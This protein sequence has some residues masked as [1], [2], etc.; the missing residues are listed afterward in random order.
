MTF[1]EGKS[2]SVKV[3]SEVKTGIARGIDQ[4]GCL[5]LEQNQ[6][7]ISICSGHIQSVHL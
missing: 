2:L 5:R 7:L 1:L 6:G 4:N 3:G